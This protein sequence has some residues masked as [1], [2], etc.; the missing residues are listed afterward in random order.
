LGPGFGGLYAHIDDCKQIGHRL[1]LLHGDLLHSLDVANLIM[2]GIDDLDVLDIWD[3]IPSIAEIFHVVLETLI[4]LLPDGLQHLYY[5]W[6][7][8]R[9]LKVPN[10]HDT[11]SWVESWSSLDHLLRRPQRP[12]DTPE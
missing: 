10:E 6:T 8:V 9:A 1:R 3:V 12:S 7:L 11:M 5:R 2:E 4:M